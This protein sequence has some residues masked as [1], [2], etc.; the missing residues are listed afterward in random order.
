MVTSAG[1]SVTF[2]FEEKARTCEHH[3][4]G[5]SA[6]FGW[7]EHTAAKDFGD[8]LRSAVRCLT[9]GVQR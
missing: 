2:L 9:G 5:Q 4:P 7:A 8:Q 3:P 6:I 1:F